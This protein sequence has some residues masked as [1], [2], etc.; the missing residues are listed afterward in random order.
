[1]ANNPIISRFRSL[2]LKNRVVDRIYLIIPYI[3]WLIGISFYAVV[4]FALPPAPTTD[5][6]DEVRAILD[7]PVPS[8]SEHKQRFVTNTI[9]SQYQALKIDSEP[10][11]YSPALSDAVYA[12]WQVFWTPNQPFLIDPALN[13]T[14]RRKIIEYQIQCRLALINGRD[15]TKRLILRTPLPKTEVDRLYLLLSKGVYIWGG[16]FFQRHGV[17]YRCYCLGLR[18]FVF[19]GAFLEFFYFLFFNDVEVL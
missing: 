1:M 8:H 10:P 9:A 17:L 11:V 14:W 13:W 3:P 12:A 15:P 5:Y 7:R 19:G 2:S 16:A 6:H 4:V 18:V